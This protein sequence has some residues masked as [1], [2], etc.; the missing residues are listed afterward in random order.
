MMDFRVSGCGVMAG[1][2][3]PQVLRG[4][5][6]AFSPLM[7]QLVEELTRPLPIGDPGRDPRDWDSTR[8][9]VPC[10]R[11]SNDPRMDGP[12]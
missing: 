10:I 7:D 3:S 9:R 8:H 6:V 5:A 4:A 2:S 12:R 11:G 1:E